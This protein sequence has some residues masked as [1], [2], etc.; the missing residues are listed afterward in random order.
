MVEKQILIPVL[1]IAVIVWWLLVVVVL[2]R[3]EVLGH[4]KP[5][6]R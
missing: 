6:C 5:V 3:G 2:I 1:S 4:V